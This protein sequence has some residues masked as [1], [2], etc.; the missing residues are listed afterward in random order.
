MSH[1]KSICHLKCT[2]SWSGYL[3]AKSIGSLV[4]QISAQNK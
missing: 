4:A 1:E 2:A 3:S